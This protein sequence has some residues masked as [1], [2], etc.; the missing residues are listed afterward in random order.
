MKHILNSLMKEDDMA[1]NLLPWDWFKD[2]ESKRG[3]ITHRND[4]P[5]FSRIH[6]E[7]EKMMNDMFKD[8]LP[9]LSKNSGKALGMSFLTPKINISEKEDTYKISAEIPGVDEKDIDLSMS[10]GMLNIRAEKKEEKEDKD[11]QYH[12]YERYYG[13]FTRSISLPDNIDENSIEAK[14][15]NGV[16]NISIKKSKEAKSATKKIEVKGS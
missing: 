8:Y 9:S 1:R 12:R 6:S 15:K 16:L 4:F 10:N 14:F 5:S 2:E 3:Q 13:T 7:M 11:E